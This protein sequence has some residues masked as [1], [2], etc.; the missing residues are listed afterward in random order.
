LVSVVYIIIFDCAYSTKTMN[1]PACEHCRNM[2][3]FPAYTQRFCPH[4][5]L[6]VENESI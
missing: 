6:H 2:K 5:I 3:Q 4:I 1:A